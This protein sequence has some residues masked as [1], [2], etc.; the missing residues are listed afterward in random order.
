MELVF[1]CIYSYAPT[2]LLLVLQAV[3]TSRAGA[4]GKAGRMLGAVLDILGAQCPHTSS[5]SLQGPSQLYRTATPSSTGRWKIPDAV[6]TK[7]I[8]KANIIVISSPLNTR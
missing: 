4:G 7:P 1:L 8:G 6:D 5:G 2:P 3:P